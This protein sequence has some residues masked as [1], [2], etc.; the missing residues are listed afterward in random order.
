MYK[1]GTTRKGF[2]CHLGKSLSFSYSLTLQ[3]CGSAISQI[4]RKASG[5]KREQCL[6][7]LFEATENAD[8]SNSLLEMTGILI[9]KF[10]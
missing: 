3:L 7:I 5:S 2:F 10:R 9:E 6:E 1:L 8:N 4:I